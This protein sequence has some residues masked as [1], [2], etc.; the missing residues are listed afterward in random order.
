MAENDIPLIKKKR[1]SE[2]PN[3]TLEMF[4]QSVNEV[5]KAIYLLSKQGIDSL[6]ETIEDSSI[7]YE[8]VTKNLIQNVKE[9]TRETLDPY[10]EILIDT[11]DSLKDDST[12]TYIEVSTNLNKILQT[13]EDNFKKGLVSLTDKVQATYSTLNETFL[14]K[15]EGFRSNVLDAIET[16]KN[17]IENK[18]YHIKTGVKELSSKVKKDTSLTKDYLAESFSQAFEP[19][20]EMIGHILTEGLQKKDDIKDWISDL[21]ETNK[22]LL[23]N[24]K[25][26]AEE[27]ISENKEFITGV[28][29]DIQDHLK[30]TI[31]D[32][33]YPIE[34]KFLDLKIGVEDKLADL[35]FLAKEKIAYPI[36]NKFLDFKIGA[37]EI[38]ADLK[39]VAQEK[40]AP[41]EDKIESASNTLIDLAT[42]V[43]N[44]PKSSTESFE[45]L[46]KSIKQGFTD[47]VGHTKF[48]LDDI[49]METISAPR[50][51]SGEYISE[52]TEKS[53][54]PPKGVP[55]V[56]EVEESVPLPKGV[57]FVNE[58]VDEF[59]S[60]PPRES[61]SSS[62]KEPS[63]VD[64]P[65]AK[66]SPTKEKAPK[67]KST[68]EGG[69]NS[70]LKP[71]Q[72]LSQGSFPTES[73]SIRK[74]GLLGAGFH[75]L[76]QTIVDNSYK[77]KARKSGGSLRDLPKKVLT[78][79]KDKASQFKEIITGLPSMLKDMFN[80]K[81]PN[82]FGKKK[83]EDSK[84]PDPKENQAVLQDPLRRLSEGIYVQDIN[85]IKR[86]GLIGAG[87]A[88]LASTIEKA[89]LGSVKDK[90]KG[91]SLFG[92]GVGGL[93]GAMGLGGIA[94]ALGIKVPK[95]AGLTLKG[96]GLSAGL[97][98]MIID[99]AKGFFESEEWGTSKVGG[100]IGGILA[101]TEEGLIGTGMNA[102]KW[103]AIGTAVAPGIGTIIGGLI[104]AGLGWLGGE[105]LAKLT[106]TT[107]ERI[108]I[109]SILKDQEATQLEKLG[110][111]VGNVTG[112][113]V[114]GVQDLSKLFVKKIE[115]EYDVEFKELSGWEKI[116]ASLAVLTEATFDFMTSLTSAFRDAVRGKEESEALNTLLREQGDFDLLG[117]TAQSVA[118]HDLENF[119]RYQGELHELLT[120]DV[121]DLTQLKQIEIATGLMGEFQ[122]G[123]DKTVGYKVDTSSSLDLQAVRRSLVEEQNIQKANKDKKSA[124]R[125]GRVLEN[126]EIL[127]GSIAENTSKSN[128]VVVPME[129]ELSELKVM[130]GSLM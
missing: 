68:S 5:S 21:I 80:E 44:L 10:K 42:K 114:S 76:A 1:S 73:K 58:V 122:K 120:D 62:E 81:F 128:S 96:A 125:I 30:T 117:E 22:N 119:L 98:M 101:G 127:L 89:G 105:N 124:E 28:L 16:N 37:E 129:K 46:T 14:A 25:Y 99:G 77:G 84:I 66:K 39:F 18:K 52:V 40:L 26:L 87:F 65:K 6:R 91:G 82:F 79:V 27:K 108:D 92:G 2:I 71:I 17:I 8:E 121:D 106:D 88:L 7:K 51:T 70:L 54:L 90:P 13:Q 53:P 50:K 97:V 118:R 102:I 67:S 72:Q 32:I 61:S 115:D 123:L 36:E 75:M 78:K 111:I 109:D 69:L 94:K 107:I 112:A 19:T 100:V 34:N 64:A 12:K 43:I 130:S 55:F 31:S 86:Q 85:V 24:K 74:H 49:A 47:I 60:L 59:P 23:E 45:K 20:R 35:K 29:K 126:L 41:F 93:L 83:E 9:D 3:T 56:N 116:K 104:G 15:T 4:N 103:A 95:G 11:V 48:M 38:F 63:K 110:M 57:P 113:L 33:A